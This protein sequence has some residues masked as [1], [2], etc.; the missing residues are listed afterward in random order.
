MATPKWLQSLGN[1]LHA[2]VSVVSPALGQVLAPALGVKTGVPT[3]AQIPAAATPATS[4]APGPQKTFFKGLPKW[5]LPAGAVAGGIVVIL[6]LT[7]K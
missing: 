1:S 5:V 6:L 7:R 4:P 3:Q 2:V